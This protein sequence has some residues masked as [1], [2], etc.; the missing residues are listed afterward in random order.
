M[1]NNNQISH[2]C[3]NCGVTVYH[4]QGR[5]YAPL[6]HQLLTGKIIHPRGE[7]SD[8]EFR[9][10]YVPHDC[11]PETVD[12]FAELRQRALDGLGLLL[13][14]TPSSFDQADLID[15][16]QSTD[17][18]IAHLTEMTEQYGLTLECPRCGA[19]IGQ[20]CENL[21]ERKHGRLA[22]TRRPH[23]TRLP[24][25]DTV[26]AKHLETIRAEVGDAVTFM[27]QINE[28]LEGENALERLT[29]LVR[30]Y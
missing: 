24:Y 18:K 23:E 11:E 16:K 14:V 30:G 9:F 12:K 29:A 3:P 5:D 6:A 13:A 4:H 22:Y 15:A 21:S 27:N 19:G 10:A 17:E 20:P 2:S 25:A 7:S 1:W 26:E 28:A 8:M